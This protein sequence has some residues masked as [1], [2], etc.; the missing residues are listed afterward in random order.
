[1]SSFVDFDFDTWK[2]LAAR[3]PEAFEL[4]RKQLLE[5]EISAAPEEHQQRLRG[6]QWQVDATRKRFKHPQVSCERLFGLMWEKV[7]GENGFLE[8]LTG[9]HQKPNTTDMAM[10]TSKVIPFRAQ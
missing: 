7:Y 3:D 4:Q 6:I 9:N 5:A 1:M 2:E 8:A 10:Q